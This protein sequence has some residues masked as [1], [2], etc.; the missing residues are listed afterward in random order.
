[1]SATALPAIV[2]TCGHRADKI[3]RDTA[4]GR[5]YAADLA[6][7]EC[8]DCYRTAANAAASRAAAELHLP[9]LTGPDTFG[10]EPS[11]AQTR[12]ATALR[13]SWRQRV[14]S[15][16]AG[17]DVARMAAVDAALYGIRSATWWIDRRKAQPDAIL[18]ELAPVCEVVIR[19]YAA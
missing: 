8:A 4:R 3:V 18:A 6:A 11:E 16:M 9:D 10:R 13:E 2:H 12:W 7:R 14:G 1:M 17:A 19:E 5:A 15:Y